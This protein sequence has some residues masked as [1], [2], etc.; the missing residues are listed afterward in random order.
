MP[1]QRPTCSRSNVLTLRGLVRYVVCFVTKLKTRRVTIAGIAQQ[2]DETWIMQVARNLTA[3]GDGFPNGIQNVILDRDPPY[4]TAF[5]R[6]LRFVDCLSRI[7]ARR[8]A[9]YR[10][11][12]HVDTHENLLVW[13]GYRSRDDESKF[14]STSCFAPNIQFSAY[15]LCSLANAW[16]TPV[17]RTAAFLQH[18]RVHSFPIVPH[19]Q[20]KLVFVVQKFSLDPARLCVAESIP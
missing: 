18:L 16:Q 20:P 10:R 15:L 9:V 3:A 17:S 19:T 13:V 4:T 11:C 2:P 14:G 8:L 7:R 1:W 5:R 12:D 6:L